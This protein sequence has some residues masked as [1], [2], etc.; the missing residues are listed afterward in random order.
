MLL[1]ADLDA[2]WSILVIPAI[3]FANDHIHKIQSNAW[4]I[5][6]NVTGVLGC[7]ISAVRCVY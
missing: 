3:L 7:W 1:P 2:S 5:V 6:R 4:L